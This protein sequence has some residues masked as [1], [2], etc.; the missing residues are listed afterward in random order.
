M[1]KNVA[2][3]K[4]KLVLVENEL[5]KLLEKVKAVSTIGLT[6]D[7]INNFNTLFGENLARI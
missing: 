3:S 5:Q 4:T 7:L 2:S 1:N 6:K